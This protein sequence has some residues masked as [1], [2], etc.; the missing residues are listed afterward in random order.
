MNLP[1]VSII[2]RTTHRST[3][4]VAIQSVERQ[5]YRPLELVLVDALGTGFPS[6]LN[7]SR[8]IALVT[9]SLGKSL[10]YGDAANAGLD[11]AGGEYIVFL[12]DD[13][14]F[15]A[16][17]IACRLDAINHAE[18]INGN[19]PLL[20]YGPTRH[21][22]KQGVEKGVM[23]EEYSPIKLHH[24]NYIQIGAALFS[25][26]LLE[27][28]CRFDARFAGLVDWD[29][30]LQASVH[31]SFAYTPC[32][33]NN[34]CADG[35]ESGAGVG[36]NFDSTKFHR[37]H[38]DLM[39]KWQVRYEQLLTAFEGYSSIAF[40][41]LQRGDMEKAEHGYREAARF[42]ATDGS[43][44]GNLAFIRMQQG[45]FD[46]ATILLKRAITYNPQHVDARINL[47]MLCAQTGNVAE[48]VKVLDSLLEMDPRHVQALA[49]RVRLTA[50]PQKK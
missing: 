48:A 36:Q 11:V 30:W 21:V 34:W 3:L 37:L 24:H 50:M 15:G 20:A 1:T 25:R 38:R 29:F 49:L 39:A 2:I 43:V 26:H 16:E 46:A 4:A 12:D 27:K 22:D 9:R 28:G 35:G 47:A 17:H 33:T 41:A 23:A 7:V 8:E 40:A 13:D 5:T 6:P 45:D 42:D 32:V 18:A 19:K 10:G 31:T 44:L 14:F